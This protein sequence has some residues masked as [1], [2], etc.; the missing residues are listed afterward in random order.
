MSLGRQASRRFWRG[1]MV[2]SWFW[3]VHLPRT[4]H[5]ISDSIA[6]FEALAV[7]GLPLVVF[8]HFTR[9]VEVL[10]PEPTDDTA[11]GVAAPAQRAET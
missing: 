11:R 4:L 6:V 1:L 5:G 8:G 3:I 7:S 9:A 10:V 2:L